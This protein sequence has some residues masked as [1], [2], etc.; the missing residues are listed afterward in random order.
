M[1]NKK[2]KIVGNTPER[3]GYEG[4]G[5]PSLMPTLLVEVIIPLKYPSNIWN[6]L[7]Q[8][9]INCEIKL[10]LSWTKD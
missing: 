10:D 2:T 3:P 6:S 5:N 4:Y 9:L 7:A 8:P 1:Q